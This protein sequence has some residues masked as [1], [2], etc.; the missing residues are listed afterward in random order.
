MP[1]KYITSDHPGLQLHTLEGR[2]A[3][4]RGEEGS[5]GGGTDTSPASRPPSASSVHQSLFR[6]WL[7][8]SEPKNN[9]LPALKAG[10]PAVRKTVRRATQLSIDSPSEINSMSTDRSTIRWLVLP[11]QRRSSFLP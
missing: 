6:G 2:I 9:P 10:T 7:E 4:F 11:L 5:S 3:A 1:R 8:I